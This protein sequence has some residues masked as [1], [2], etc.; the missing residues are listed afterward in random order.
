MNYLPQGRSNLNRPGPFSKGLNG[1]R[2]REGRV[3]L[4]RRLCWTRWRRSFNTNL[5][6]ADAVLGKL[7]NNGAKAG[8]SKTTSWSVVCEG[9]EGKPST[10]QLKKAQTFAKGPGRRSEPRMHIISEGVR[11]DSLTET[12]LPY[13]AQPHCARVHGC[14]PRRRRASSPR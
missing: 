1:W 5:N 14:S 6:G 10:Y 7:V 3:R 12:V 4:S 2:V 13:I 11:P 9:N 8:S